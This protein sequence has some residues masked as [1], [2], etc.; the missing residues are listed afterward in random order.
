[1]KPIVLGKSGSTNVA[2]DLR[3]LL[4]TRLLIQANSGG[5]KS[6]VL[7]RLIEQLYGKVQCIVIDIAGEFSSLRE[8]FDF[9]LAG[10]GGE[11]PVDVRSAALVATKL[12]E[13]RANAVCDLYSLK[14]QDRHVWM[15]NFLGAVMNAPKKLWHPVVFAIDEAHKFMPEKGEGESAAKEEMLSLCSDGRK[16]GYCSIL[17]TQRLAKLDKSGAAEMLNVLIGPTFLDVD[18]ERAHKALGI[19]RSEWK[20]F[21]AEMKS[22]EPGNFYALGRAI[23]KTRI[24]VKVGD[25]KTTHPEPGE[26]QYISAPPPSVKIRSLLPQLADLPKLAEAKAKTEQELRAELSQVRRELLAAQKSAPA[27]VETQKVIEKVPIITN[28]ELQKLEKAFVG[29]HKVAEKY[30]TVGVELGNQFSDFG[31]TL[32]GA[33]SGLSALL[34]KA[35][36]PEPLTETRALPKPATL[37]KPITKSNFRFENATAIH[38]F[39]RAMIK[40]ANLVRAEIGDKPRV[41]IK[42]MVQVLAQFPDGRTDTQLRTLAFIPKPKTYETYKSEMMRRGFSEYREGRNFITDAGMSF[43]GGDI[44]DQPKSTNELLELWC[45]L[46]RAGTG[47]I[48]RRIVSAYPNPV[49]LAEFIGDGMSEKT[50]I[51]Y[52]SELK[53]NDLAE[54][55]G[56]RIKASD[57]FFE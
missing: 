52:A 47:K 5:G 14:P 30:L 2:I 20:A 57:V 16:Y 41:G 12:L 17:A 36:V 13:L 10:E 45:S 56:S 53:S 50:V 51:T 22:N 26:A 34:Q 1:M 19:I 9:V 11:T 29:F 15:K 7:R 33:V 55:N 18:L 37:T 42:R 32:S 35:V 3:T 25:V 6:W 8:K 49:E 54:V 4:L 40:P 46:F 31:Q 44:P 39:D 27:R 21:D 24:L 23:S 43:L 38:R 28:G 48:L